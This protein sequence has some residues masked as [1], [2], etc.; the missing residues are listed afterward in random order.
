M[1][2]KSWIL[3][4]A[5][6]ALLAGCGG[7]GDN[8]PPVTSQVPASASATITGFISYIQALIASNADTL[9]PVDVSNVTPPKDETSSPISVD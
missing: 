5:T 6:A 8:N 9:Q 7:G 2:R 1:N 4:A 3:A